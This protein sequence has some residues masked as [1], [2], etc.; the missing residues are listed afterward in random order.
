MEKSF[1]LLPCLFQNKNKKV[2]F[3]QLSIFC[4]LRIYF[5]NMAKKM[6]QIKKRIK[7]EV[8]GFINEKS[9]LNKI[10]MKHVIEK[11][12]TVWKRKI[13]KSETLLV[14]EYV[15]EKLKRL[16]EAQIIKKVT[17]KNNMKGQKVKKNRKKTGKPV[18][19]FL[20]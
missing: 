19:I 9:D 11:V 4:L 18:I 20:F 1:L 12:E 3:P 17:Q 6:A 8:D 10:T 5:A 13:N 14:A 2:L 16:P 15:N 7:K